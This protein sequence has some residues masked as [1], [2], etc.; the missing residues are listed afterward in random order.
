MI[1]V[2]VTCKDE[3]QAKELAKALLEERLTACANIF[4]IKSMYWWEEA[5]TEDSEF[6]LLLKT[7]KEKYDALKE[8]IKELHSYKTPCILKFDAEPNQ[9][10]LN[11]LEGELL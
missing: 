10:Y 2:Y 1:V 8:R 9:E 7:K 5:I 6:V 3:T 11:W 4:P